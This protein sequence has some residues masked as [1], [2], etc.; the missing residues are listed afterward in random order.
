MGALEA[1]R[2]REGEPMKKAGK[3]I[4]YNGSVNDRCDAGVAYQELAGS[5]PGWV[6]RLPCL[7]KNDGPGMV[8][9]ALR[10]EPTAAE[11]E[12]DEARLKDRLERVG[13]VRDA[14]VAACGGPWKRGTPGAQGEIAC[15]C[16]GGTVRYSRAGYN[17]HVHARCSTE[18][19]VSWME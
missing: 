17:G 10:Q 8:P 3:C 12:D 19:C 7:R 18:D 16:C 15:P 14:I 4:H 5:E 6:R 1:T 13:K 11:V 2:K 9:C